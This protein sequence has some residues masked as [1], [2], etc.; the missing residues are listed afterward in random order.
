MLGTAIWW[1]VWMDASAA[2]QLAAIAGLAA[3]G[4][5][6]LQRLCGRRRLG[7]D[8]AIVLDEVVGA[9]IALLF[10]PPEP[11]AVAAAFAL[12]RLFDICKPWPISWVDRRVKGGIGVVLDDALAGMLAFGALQGGLLVAGV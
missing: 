2:A 11:W 10:V 3:A 6:L 8:C 5:L 12:F 7:D 1:L 9:W 4:C